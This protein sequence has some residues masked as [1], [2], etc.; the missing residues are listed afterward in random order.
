VGLSPKTILMKTPL[1]MLYLPILLI[2]MGCDSD[3]TSNDGGVAGSQQV[4]IDFLGQV[5]S[6][7]YECGST[8]AGLGLGPSELTPSDFRLFISEVELLD[9]SGIGHAVSLDQ[10]GKWQF[11]NVALLDFDNGCAGGNTDQNSAVLGNVESGTYVGIR[12]TLGVP[13]EHNHIDSST[14]PA[15]LSLTSM[16]W[17]WQQGYKFVRIEGASSGLPGWRFH[18]GSTGCNGDARG[19][20]TMCSEPNRATIELVGFDPTSVPIVVDLAS[21]VSGSDLEEDTGGAEGCMGSLG[22]PECAA[23]FNT[24]GLSAGST[25]VFFRQP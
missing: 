22:D 4:R 15:P 10:D 11:D 14:A 16:F 20:V 5:G 6:E 17:G 18:L 9:E 3:Q 7:A 21:L 24:V 12:F 1:A 13:F 25:Q 2:G 19:N 23:F 8:Y